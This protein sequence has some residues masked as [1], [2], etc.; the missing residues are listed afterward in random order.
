VLIDPAEK[1]KIHRLKQQYLE[2]VIPLLTEQFGYTNIHQVFAVLPRPI[3]S[4]LQFP[5]LIFC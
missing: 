2:K 5:L 1:E 4:V 3:L